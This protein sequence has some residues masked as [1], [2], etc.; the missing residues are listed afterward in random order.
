MTKYKLQNLNI[1]AVG[2]EY[3]RKSLGNSTENYKA[4]FLKC[5]SGFSESAVH[6]LRVSIRR[7]REAVA[8]ADRFM[9][10]AYTSSLQKALKKQFSSLSV[11]RDCQVMIDKTREMMYEC[12]ELVDFLHYLLN[13]ETAMIEKLSKQFAFINFSRI[14]GLLLFFKMEADFKLKEERVTGEKINIIIDER[15]NFAS[16]MRNKANPNSV[17]TIHDFRKSFKK[18]RYLIEFL[19]PVLGLSKDEIKPFNTYQTLM[20]KIQDAEVYDIEFQM[21]LKTQDSYNKQKY[22]EIE[23]MF[24]NKKTTTLKDFTYN[25]DLLQDFWN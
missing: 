23:Y 12:H 11:I 3:L 7:L 24:R 14:E 16:D 10:S 18:I 15:Y 5:N 17:Q 19:A 20:G 13:K 1:G 4:A 25:F 8:F 6:D 2:A 21:F 22:N 9:D